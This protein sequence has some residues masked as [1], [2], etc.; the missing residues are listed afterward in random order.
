MVEEV[1]QNESEGPD[2]GLS[3]VVRRSKVVAT[4]CANFQLQIHT[5]KDIWTHHTPCRA[6][7]HSQ[8]PHTRSPSSPVPNR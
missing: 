1:E 5:R 2:V 8:S 7:S 6:Y 3:R 4:F